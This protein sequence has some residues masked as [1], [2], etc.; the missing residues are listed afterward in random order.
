M[1]LLLDHGLRCGELEWSHQAGE[2]DVSAETLQAAAELLTLR[3][4]AIRLIDGAGPN[5]E[6]SRSAPTEQGSGSEAEPEYESSSAEKPANLTETVGEHAEMANSAPPDQNEQEA[7]CSRAKDQMQTRESPKCT[8]P[9]VVPIEPERFLESGV[10]LVECPNCAR[11]R[12]LSPRNGVLRFPAH[13]KRKTN[14]PN[15]DRRWA[16]GETAWEVVGG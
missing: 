13:S 14:T 2:T 7:G 1:C 6:V 9:S 4:D 12:T 11:T 3:R 8:A 16:M 15:T 5:I 10:A